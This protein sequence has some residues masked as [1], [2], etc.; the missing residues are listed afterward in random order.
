MKTNDDKIFDRIVNKKYIPKIQEIE[1]KYIFNKLVEKFDL[2]NYNGEN[3]I[4]FDN[5]VDVQ[6]HRQQMLVN[7]FQYNFYDK[8]V[9][10]QNKSYQDNQNPV[11]NGKIVTHSY[12]RFNRNKI[13]VP[14]VKH[15]NRYNNFIKMFG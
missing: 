9:P 15:K 11:T 1:S 8:F 5:N 3:F 2:K 7:Y 12:L 6:L 13:R 4:Y 10:I 14:S